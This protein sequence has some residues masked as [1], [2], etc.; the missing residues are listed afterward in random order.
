M[1]LIYISWLFINF[2]FLILERSSE[3]ECCF[4]I[5]DTDISHY[6]INFRFRKSSGEFTSLMQGESLQVEIIGKRIWLY[7][8]NDFIPSS[9]YDFEMFLEFSSGLIVRYY[10]YDLVIKG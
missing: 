5:E 3:R 10:Y 1:V 9:K 2:R 4:S 6:S 7:V 8:T